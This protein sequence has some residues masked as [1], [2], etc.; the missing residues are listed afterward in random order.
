MPFRKSSKRMKFIGWEAD[1]FSLSIFFIQSLPKR[2][3]KRF[4]RLPLYTCFMHLHGFPVTFP[5]ALDNL[6]SL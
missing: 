3:H 2:A 5:D 6:K 1:V 4:P